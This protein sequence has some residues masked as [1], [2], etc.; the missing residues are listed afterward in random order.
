MAIRPRKPLAVT[1]VRK[2]ARRQR[3]PQ[4]LGK[5]YFTI[6]LDQPIK[7]VLYAVAR[8]TNEDF[9]VIL[10]TAIRMGFGLP[11]IEEATENIVSAIASGTT[12]NRSYFR[13]D[14]I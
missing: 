7:D 1:R 10:R 3:G 4:L 5:S 9:A 13:E 11:T 8:E 2:G 14:A 6:G 12:P